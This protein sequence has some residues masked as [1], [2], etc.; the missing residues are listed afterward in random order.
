M[1]VSGFSFVKNA[2]KYDYPIIEAITSILPICDE[3]IVAVGDS[4]DDTLSLIQSINSDKIKIVNTVWDT[5]REGGR[6]LALETDKALAAVAKD[7]TWAFYIQGDEVM[8]EKYHDTVLSAMQKYKDSPEVDGLLFRYKHFYASYKYLVNST[9]A[10]D[11]EIRVIRPHRGIYSYRDAQGFRKGDNQKLKVK[12]IDAEIY[13]Y[14]WVKPPQTMQSKQEN[15]NKLWHDDEWIE[16]NVPKV[17]EYDYSQ[18][19]SLSLFDGTHPQVMQKRVDNYKYDFRYDMRHN[20]VKPKERI[21]RIFKS[22]GINLS[23][24]NYIKI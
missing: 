13:H 11:R 8:H 18:I 24:K 21:K 10:Y 9:S 5:T 17:A 1:K 15:F 2:I 12:E 7:S 23:Y 6:V 22:I 14:G 4:E 20:K 16:Q 3:F 19:D